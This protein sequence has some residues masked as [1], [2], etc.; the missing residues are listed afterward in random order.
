MKLF[1]TK[2]V[3]DTIQ[4]LE[5][6]PSYSDL[7]LL[8]YEYIRK[9]PGFQDWDSAS[10]LSNVSPIPHIKM[11]LRGKGGYRVYYVLIIK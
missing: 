1:A 11:R 6:K 5:K 8:F 10:K 7:R 3:V 2:S 9:H 4:K